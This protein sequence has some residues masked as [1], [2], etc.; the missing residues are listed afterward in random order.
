LLHRE[1]IKNRQAV[2]PDCDPDR[3]PDHDPGRSKADT[4]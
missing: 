2:D 4:G 1:A 3:D